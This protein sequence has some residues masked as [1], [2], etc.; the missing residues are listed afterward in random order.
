MRLNLIA[1][2]LLAGC[3]TSHPLNIAEQCEIYPAIEWTKLSA[4]PAEAEQL[5][6]LASDERI[7]ERQ[8]SMSGEV[9]FRSDSGTIRYCRYTRSEDPRDGPEHR[10]FQ[11]YYGSGMRRGTL[12][13][14]CE[15]GA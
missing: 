3:T 6:K 12:P 14:L 8:A 11:F 4:P 13:D 9:G 15:C 1:W 7:T 2:L 5:L 10:D